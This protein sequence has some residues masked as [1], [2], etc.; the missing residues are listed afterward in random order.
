MVSLVI[1]TL[2]P[3]RASSFVLT[4]VDQTCA[5]M[6]N[7]SSPI[8]LQLRHDAARFSG[9][10]DDEPFGVHG[11]IEH[12]PSPPRRAAGSTAEPPCFFGNSARRRNPAQPR[13]ERRGG[14]AAG[15]KGE[16]R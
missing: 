1:F 10:A 6:H 13:H 2:G 3:A 8:M 5:A 16:V 9:E 14:R 15:Q 11:C 4:A 12:A 7:A